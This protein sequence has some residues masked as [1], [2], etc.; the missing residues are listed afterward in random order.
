MTSRAGNWI[1]AAGA[2]AAFCGACTLPAALGEH[3]DTALLGLGACLLSVGAFL[4]ASGIYWKA[5]ALQ[6]QVE[7]GVTEGEAKPSS[8]RVRG[9]CE[10]CA[11]ETPVIQCRVH[12][13]QLCP[14]CLAEHYDP[15][16]CA[17]V[18]P[19]RKPASR[20]GKSMA[21]KRGA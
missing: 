20:A 17:Y 10:L 18:P 9:G 5:R 14:T 3:R 12:Q 16:S 13:L 8:R 15:R 7:A 19:T 6:S 1:I 21:A 11:S 2:L 4:A